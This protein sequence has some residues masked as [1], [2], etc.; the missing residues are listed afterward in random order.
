MSKPDVE[1]EGKDGPGI[2]LQT[3]LMVVSLERTMLHS[4][5]FFLR[6]SFCM[7]LNF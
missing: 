4:I 5:I 1:A 6:N 3:N 7:I 2:E